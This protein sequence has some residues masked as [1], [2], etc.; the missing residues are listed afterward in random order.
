MT[1]LLKGVT[2]ACV[3]SV[4]LQSFENELVTDILT[5]MSCYSAKSYGR[6]SHM[7][8]KKRK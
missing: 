2:I 6:R 7:T 8:K 4:L 1:L 3:E 5:I